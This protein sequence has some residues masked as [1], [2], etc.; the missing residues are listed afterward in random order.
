M[1]KLWWNGVER[2]GKFLWTTSGRTIFRQWRG[3]ENRCRGNLGH[4]V[5]SLEQTACINPDRKVPKGEPLRPVSKVRGQQLITAKPTARSGSKVPAYISASSRTRNRGSSAIGHNYQEC[6]IC[7]HFSPTLIPISCASHMT[8]CFRGT[9]GKSLIS[10][11]C[12]NK[13]GFRGAVGGT[14]VGRVPVAVAEA[15]F[16]QENVM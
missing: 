10:M 14:R 12:R 9:T 16:E 5:A 4:L 8:F 1:L 3:P 15:P 2:R 11:C 7:D 13:N 6:L